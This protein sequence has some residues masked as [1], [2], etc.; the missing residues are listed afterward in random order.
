MPLSNE[1]NSLLITNNCNN[2]GLL[3]RLLN[4]CCQ[5]TSKPIKQM[6]QAQYVKFSII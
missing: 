4:I 6:L 3:H 1:D 2:L 5:V